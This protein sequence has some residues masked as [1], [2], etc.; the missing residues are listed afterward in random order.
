MKRLLCRFTRGKAVPGWLL[1][2]FRFR[3]FFF[4]RTFEMQTLCGSCRFTPA[5]SKRI[6]HV[7][8]VRG[9]VSVI[10]TGGRVGA[11]SRL[12]AIS[13]TT[14]DIPVSFTSGPWRARSNTLENYCN[15]ALNRSGGVLERIRRGCSCGFT[16]AFVKGKK[17]S[18]S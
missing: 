2:A 5:Q 6:M 11:Q 18:Y 3:T 13:A 16:T 15:Q 1:T 14:L 8:C 12:R 9:C 7:A 4:H 10:S 17:N